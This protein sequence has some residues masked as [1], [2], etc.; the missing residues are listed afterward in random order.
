MPFQKRSLELIATEGEQESKII[1]GKIYF[2]Y[3]LLREDGE[4]FGKTK[5]LLH[6][7]VYSPHLPRNPPPLG[8]IL[9]ESGIMHGGG[10]NHG[11][12]GFED[13]CP[14]LLYIPGETPEQAAGCLNQYRNHIDEALFSSR[15]YCPCKVRPVMIGK[16][17]Y[18]V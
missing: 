15:R 14:V 3:E 10:G 17:K 11:F 2:I 18:P 7:S 4:W 12:L 9:E 6:N 8:Q 16:H 13:T 5:G 1:D